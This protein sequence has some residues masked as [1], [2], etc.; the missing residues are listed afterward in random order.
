LEVLVAF[1][2]LALALSALIQAFSQSIRSSTVAEERATAVMLARSKM[3]EIGRSIPLVESELGG[4]FAGGLGWQLT[5]SSRE[6]TDID[7]GDGA[8][9]NIYDIVLIVDRDNSGL[10]EVRSL[11]VGAAP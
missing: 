9:L 2:I 11:R 10:V 6:D 4:N 3:A 8:T 5:I 1:M 7:A